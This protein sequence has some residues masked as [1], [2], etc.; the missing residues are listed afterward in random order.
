MAVQQSKWRR[1]VRTGALVSAAALVLSQ[2]ATES[3]TEKIVP[4]PQACTEE[5]AGPTQPTD[6]SEP[7]FIAE[8]HSYL[9]NADDEFLA[10]PYLVIYADVSFNGGESDKKNPGTSQNTVT[11]TL[12]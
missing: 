6:D 4:E 3:D 11:I 1:G 2:C 7:I 9:S 8:N 12:H 5:H 10:R